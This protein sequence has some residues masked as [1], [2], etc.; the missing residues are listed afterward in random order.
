MKV[1]GLFLYC[2]VISISVQADIATSFSKAKKNLY[3]KV[4]NNSG[5]T[6]YANCSWS[7]KKVDLESCNLQDSFPKKYLKRALR[8]EAEHVIPSSWMYRKNGEWRQCY[9][10]AKTKGVN[11]RKYCQKTDMDY[12]NAHNDLMN[13]VPAVGQLNGLRSNKPFAEKVSGKKEQTF[14]GAGKVFVV[15]S[16]VAI[17]DVS[18]RGDI[19]RIAFYM[20]DTYGVTYSKRQLALFM[21]WDKEDP[22]SPE[23]RKRNQLINKIQ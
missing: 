22:L 9:V 18:I 21:K 8:T 7:K 5:L 10:E 13:L 20:E 6:F 2:M 17:P 23:E 16:R 19:A 4:Y 1:F 14:N 12:R 3:H 15:T 11:K